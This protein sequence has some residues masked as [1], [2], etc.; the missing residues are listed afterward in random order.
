LHFVDQLIKILYIN[1][2]KYCLPIIDEL[3]LIALDFYLFISLFL[4]I[5]KID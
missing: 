2:F 4:Y 1:S 3:T 5:N